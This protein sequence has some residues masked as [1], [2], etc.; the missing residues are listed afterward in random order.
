[1]FFTYEP[2]YYFVYMTSGRHFY[3]IISFFRVVNPD[4]KMD[5]YSA[6]TQL[7]TEKRLNLMTKIHRLIIQNLRHELLFLY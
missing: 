6:I 5:S 3:I 2:E 4:P 7:K 1:M